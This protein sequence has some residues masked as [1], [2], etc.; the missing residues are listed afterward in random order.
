MKSKISMKILNKK[1]LILLIPV[2]LL[3]PLG[4]PPVT[5]AQSLNIQIDE[6]N[7][8]P[9]QTIP[10]PVQLTSPP[11]QSK[12]VEEKISPGIQNFSQIGMMSFSIS[13]NR[14]DF[15]TLSPA[16]PVIRNIKLSLISEFTDYQILAYENHPPRTNNNTV[17]PDTTCDN[18]TCTEKSSSVWENS[19]TYGFGFRCV[20]LNHLFCLE[21]LDTNEYMQVANL[22]ANELPQVLIK[23]IRNKEPQEAQIDFKL[24]TAGTQPSGTYANT[25]TFIA[26]PNY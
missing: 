11:L 25:V 9:D 12:T 26:V 15:G 23:G 20:A 5:S 7:T 1:P 24:N 21:T 19:L 22:S 4:A 2:I 16:N 14:L 10:T 13:S 18:G 3:I 6:I 8:A 17:I